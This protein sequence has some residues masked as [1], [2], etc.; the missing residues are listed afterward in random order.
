MTPDV[1]DK[2]KDWIENDAKISRETMKLMLKMVK[3]PN[4]EVHVP[5]FVAFELQGKSS[6]MLKIKDRS[7]PSYDPVYDWITDNHGL[8]SQQELQIG[9]DFPKNHVK[10]AKKMDRRRRNEELLEK[11]AK[12]LRE[13]ATDFLKNFVNDPNFNALRNRLK[14]LKDSRESLK[15]IKPNKLN[16]NSDI[17]K[18]WNTAINDVRTRTEQLNILANNLEFKRNWDSQMRKYTELASAM[19]RIQHSETIKFLN[20]QSKFEEHFI[21]ANREDAIDR[22]TVD[23]MIADRLVKHREEFDF[24]DLRI[25][26]YAK[27]KNAFILT[28]NTQAFQ[29]VEDP[30]FFNYFKDVKILHPLINPNE[31]PYIDGKFDIAHFVEAA[32]KNDFNH[33]LGTLKQKNSEEFIKI[34]NRLELPV[35]KLQSAIN[36]VI[37][38]M[39]LHKKK[40]GDKE[41][42]DGRK[43]SQKLTTM[44]EAL[45]ALKMDKSGI[46][47]DAKTLF[48][49]PKRNNIK[50]TVESLEFIKKHFITHGNR[51]RIEDFVCERDSRSRKK[52]PSEI[53]D[54]IK[55][56][57]HNDSPIIMSPKKAMQEFV[58]SMQRSKGLSTDLLVRYAQ[59]LFVVMHTTKKQFDDLLVELK[60]QP[61]INKPSENGALLSAC[62]KKARRRRREAVDCSPVKRFITDDGK[63]NNDELYKTIKDDPHVHQSLIEFADEVKGKWKEPQKQN[64]K[65]IINEHKFMKHLTRV[66]TVSNCIDMGF[67][68]RMLIA[69]L[70]YG[71]FTR[72]AMNVGSIV[73]LQVASILGEVATVGG[74][75]LARS[76]KIISAN[77]LKA[78]GPFLQRLGTVFVAYDL[79]EQVKAYR[80]G[81]TDAIV[82]IIGD[83]IMIGVDLAVVGSLLLESF[84]GIAAFSAVLGPISTIIAVV[85]TIGIETFHAVRYVND[86]DSVLHLT[87]GEKWKSA[88]KS[89]LFISDDLQDAK[90]FKQWNN[91]IASNALNFLHHNKQF[92]GIILPSAVDESDDYFVNQLYANVERASNI[93]WSIAGPDDPAPDGQI[94]CSPYN[95]YPKKFSSTPYDIER[96]PPPGITH[97]CYNSI[98]VKVRNRLENSNGI[99]IFNLGPS[100]GTFEGFDNSINYFNIEEGMKTVRGANKNDVFSLVGMMGGLITID[101]DIGDNSLDISRVPGNYTVDINLEK[102]RAYSNLYIDVAFKNINTFK[103]RVHG[104][105]DVHV[106]CNTIYVNGQGGRQRNYFHQLDEI[107]I[108]ASQNCK[109]NLTIEL[110]ICTNVSNQAIQGDF[111]YIIGKNQK[112]V[113]V[114]AFNNSAANILTRHTFFMG[115]NFEDLL[116]ITSDDSI[117]DNRY[118]I[119]VNITFGTLESAFS[120]IIQLNTKNF[121]IHLIDSTEIR[122]Q[123]YGIS[124]THRTNVDLGEVR[125]KYSE[126]ADQLNVTLLLLVEH[127][128]TSVIIEGNEKHNMFRNDP[129]RNTIIIINRGDVRNVISISL[130]ESSN[131]ALFKSKVPFVDIRNVHPESTHTSID[132]RS[133]LNQAK[134]SGKELLLLHTIY[135]AD[136][137]QIDLAVKGT[138]DSYIWIFIPVK[139]C[140]DL[141]KFHIILD[142]VPLTMNCDHLHQFGVNKFK[143]AL[144]NYRQLD[145]LTPVPL[146]LNAIEIVVLTPKDLDYNMNVIVRRELGRFKWLKI[147]NSLAITH[148]EVDD[149][150]RKAF[151]ENPCTIIF[152]D[153]FTNSEL[154]YSILVMFDDVNISLNNYRDDISEARSITK[155]RKSYFKPDM[156]LSSSETA[157]SEIE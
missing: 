138:T 24:L 71:N 48:S 54:I 58:N 33:I 55:A 107:D 42:L 109:Y 122:P 95:K 22:M 43:A 50:Q 49:N 74:A 86:L 9:V 13:Q 105:D 118:K 28:R 76:G 20:L 6:K 36:S 59:N 120:T 101:G 108:P 44:F 12:E 25:Y 136:F 5:D 18:E 32:I 64:L 19:P 137:V 30:I 116:S 115:Y 98:G 47:I 56:I 132:L 141:H 147:K 154:F 61:P 27:E 23:E 130:N 69:D 156:V 99:I 124:V 88:M 91:Q 81:H 45:G 96:Q 8:V 142:K 57:H 83:S 2:T 84:A 119:N 34:T 85:I 117:E 134:K 62:V 37:S 123:E 135:A 90:E 80:N 153:F 111:R 151:A 1:R 66:E 150:N 77:L 7:V 103:G 60:S 15:L 78:A 128:N 52:D 89:I 121:S 79:V 39:Q 113:N 35:T 100:I 53:K 106:A 40:V 26:L 126:R 145:H 129:N 65:L 75:V 131:F 112:M 127:A 97:S 82:D 16:S 63:V 73:G 10:I 87:T 29:E 38:E 67:L 46:K 4:V 93:T 149:D 17:G 3:D 125:S 110:S 155:V 157:S 92:N 143:N 21:N 146:E 94:F 140:E 114:H 144:D 102:G 148:V 133:I 104:K 31:H 51:L 70:A 152:Q 11:D 68:T 14:E 72:I 41:M 139:K